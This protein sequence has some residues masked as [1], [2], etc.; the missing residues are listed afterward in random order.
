MNKKVII[1]NS[2]KLF[3]HSL[4]IIK[5]LMKISCY[6]VSK[7]QSFY[8]KQLHSSVIIESLAQKGKS[9]WNST[10][11]IIKSNNKSIWLYNLNLKQNKSSFYL[12]YPHWILQITK[13]A[14]FMWKQPKT[15]ASE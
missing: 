1:Q 13:S 7:P 12:S 6:L 2:K 8:P 11:Y 4:T 5:S 15:I 14:F 10:Q 9:E 3:E